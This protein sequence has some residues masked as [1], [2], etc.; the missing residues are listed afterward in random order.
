M[1]ERDT[2]AAAQATLGPPESR[3]WPPKGRSSVAPGRRGSAAPTNLFKNRFSTL[4]LVN[5]AIIP[6]QA[7]SLSVCLFH[8][9]HDVHSTVGCNGH[10]W[11]SNT[12]KKRTRPRLDSIDTSYRGLL[13]TPI[14]RML[15]PIR[16]QYQTTPTAAAIKRT[17]S[18]SAKYENDHH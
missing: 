9:P 16:T 3:R 11:Q 7:V 17:L 6:R 10:F 2:A 5:Q 8:G 13:V 4:L 18:I 12:P 1:A 14:N 15:L